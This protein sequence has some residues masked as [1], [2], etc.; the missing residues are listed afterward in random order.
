M[1]LGDLASKANALRPR[2][3]KEVPHGNRRRSFWTKF[4]F[5]SIR[6]A[7]IAGDA[8]GYAHEL[9]IALI[10]EATPS[11]GRVSLVGA[12]PGDPELLTLKAQRKLLEADVI[13]YDRNVSPAFWSWHGVM[14]NGLPSAPRSLTSAPCWRGKRKRQACGVSGFRRR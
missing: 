11:V 13:V 4:F 14:R 9:N 1:R 3:A 6:D 2:V 10:D 8:A 7:V 5:G 12:G